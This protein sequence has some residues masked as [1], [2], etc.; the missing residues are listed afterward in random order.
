[1]ANPALRMILRVDLS[2]GEQD[3]AQA[4][5]RCSQPVGL[6]DLYPTVA[7]MCGVEP[8]EGLDGRSLVPLLRNPS[9]STGRAVITTFDP[10]NV[11]LRTD[12]WRYIRYADGSEE[13]YD[14]RADPNEWDNLAKDPNYARRIRDLRRLVPEAAKRPQE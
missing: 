5:S 7:E 6:I 1:M 9:H 13:L 12:R 10:A 3:A 11:T 2:P 8:P 14:H 4:G